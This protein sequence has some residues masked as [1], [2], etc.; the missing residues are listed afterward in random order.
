MDLLRQPRPE[1]P[2]LRF[3]VLDIFGQLRL[4]G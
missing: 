4:G 3:Q 2:I 1:N